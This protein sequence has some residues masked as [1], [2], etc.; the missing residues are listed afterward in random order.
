MPGPAEENQTPEDW[1]AQRKRDAAATSYTPPGA[2]IVQPGQPVPAAPPPAAA[3]PAAN[4]ANPQ[5]GFKQGNSPGQPIFTQDAV[6]APMKGIAGDWFGI[7]DE[8]GFVKYHGNVINDPNAAANR[9]RLNTMIDTVGATRPNISVG[10]PNFGNA[11]AA[12]GFA[13]DTRGQQQQ[14]IGQLQNAAAG[15][16]P[17]VAQTQLQL[18]TDKNMQQSLALAS[19]GHGNAGLRMRQA[20]DARASTSQDAAA[21]SALIKA[22]EQQAAQAQLGQ[23][24]GT[25][26]TQDMGQQGADQS[27]ALSASQLQL[28]QETAAQQ[29]QQQLSDLQQKYIAMGMSAD[30]AAYQA[31]VD[32]AQFLTQSEIQQEAARNGVAIQSGQAGEKAA[33]AGIG[34]AATIAAA[35]FSDERVKTDIHDGGDKVEGFLE[36]I[37][38]HAYKYKKPKMALRGE[39]EFVS[40]MAQELERT[41]L[42]KSMVRDTPEGKVVDYGKGFGTMLATMAHLHRKVKALEASAH[43]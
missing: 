5:D 40:P 1:E 7:Q 21:Q 39:G 42:G 2:T 35:A 22:Q 14:L 16:G 32:Q 29:A 27:Q 36:T 26:R 11:N 37:G 6:S 34:A 12:R 41:E 19:S 4:P 33:A 31:K 18:A 43:A 8:D 28:Q 30:Q 20:Q 17:S 15:N 38:T 23:V 13:L 3:A 9:D 10:G 24:L 25:T